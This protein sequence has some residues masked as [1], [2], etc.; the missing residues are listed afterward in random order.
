MFITIRSGKEE[1]KKHFAISSSPTERDFIEFTK[2]LTGHR[3]S[4]ALNA[5]KVG[6]WARID[7][8]YGGFTFEVN[9]KGL[10]CSQEASG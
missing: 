3:F 5:L 2:K 9:L 10:A 6:D 4:D 1:L 8:T 7:A